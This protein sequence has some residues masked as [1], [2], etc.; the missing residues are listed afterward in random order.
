MNYRKL[1]RSGLMVSEIGFGAW[2][3]G[4]DSH[5]NSYGPT[6]DADSLAAINKALELG[7]NFF[8]TADVYGWGHSEEVLGRA[9][10]CVRKKAIIATKVGGDFYSGQVTLN[11]SADYI[12]FAAEKSLQRLKT[13]YIDIYQ[14]HNPTLEMIKKG[15]IFEPLEALKKEGKIRFYGV[16][17][18]PPIEGIEAIRL[19]RVDTIQVVY[20]IFSPEP[21]TEF[22]PLA[23]QEDIGIIAR[24]PLANGVLAGKYTVDATFPPTDIRSHW[25]RSY[26]RARIEA[27]DR[28]KPFATKRSMNLAQLAL[29]FVLAQGAVSMAIPGIKTIRQAE[30]NLH[31]SEGEPLTQEEQADLL[32]AVYG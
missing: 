15:D 9:L 8:D 30:E 1:G 4:G 29:K 24:E 25:P 19:G 17:I 21:A 5:G 20:N 7:C 14:L 10:K 23:E 28:L 27:A 31:A 18:F 6:D 11:F 12:R 32:R 3:I 22:F 13:D 26:L 2:A 16:S